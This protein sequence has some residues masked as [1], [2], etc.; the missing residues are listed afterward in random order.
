MTQ[1]GIGAGYI[2][3]IIAQRDRTASSS[4]RNAASDRSRCMLAHGFNPNLETGWFD[5]VMEV[6]NNITMLAIFLAGAAVI[7][8]REH[9][10]IEHLLVMP[11]T[12]DRDRCSPRSGPTAS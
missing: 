7:R 2:Q 11:L 1:A 3:R 4:A 6:I 5:A 10:T 8:E 12:S 9:G